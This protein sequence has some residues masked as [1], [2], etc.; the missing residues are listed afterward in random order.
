MS[1]PVR[2]LQAGTAIPPGM[3]LTHL[4]NRVL[5]PITRIKPLHRPPVFLLGHDR[6]GTTWLGRTLGLA[7]DSI[8]LHEPLNGHASQLGNWDCYN[9]HLPPDAGN[10]ACQR[11]FDQAVQGVGVRNLSRAEIRQR[12]FGNPTVVIKETGGMMNGEWFARRY[13]A[14]IAV[15]IRH[16][17]PLILSNIKMGAHNADNWLR[18]LRGQEGL[19]R[20]YCA[21]VDIDAVLGPKPDVFTK[22]AI[23]YCIR[24]RV[25]LAQLPRNPDWLNLRYE[26]FCHDPIGQFRDLFRGL[27]LNFT[28][29]V[30]NLIRE[31]CSTDGSE[32]FFGTKRMTKEMANRWRSKVAAADAA[33][34]RRVLETFDFPDYR[35]PSDW[36]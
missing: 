15:L 36:P 5:R 34:V 13:G 16:P 19:M 14:K 17:V 24:Y 11:I 3:Q 28:S 30:E 26:D 21:D 33:K 2:L 4:T 32:A 23:V 31:S 27:E 8:Y 29:S 9:L 6:S 18:K 7:P 1:P 22:F 12:V 20:E 35:D 25:V 10:E